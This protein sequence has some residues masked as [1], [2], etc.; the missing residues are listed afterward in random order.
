MARWTEEQERVLREHMH[1]GAEVC[2]AAIREQTGAR[3]TPEA[4][5]RHA[6]RIGVTRIAY[7]VCPGC[8]AKT[9]RLGR[10]S[11]LCATC[12]TAWLAE[13]QRKAR[14]SIERELE[15]SERAGLNARRAYEREGRRTRRIKARL[16]GAAGREEAAGSPQAEA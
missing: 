10:E 16:R 4:V 8:G 15:E 3:H 12:N 9:A 13:V 1:L 14:D 5:K 6:N 2:A 11:G 7:K